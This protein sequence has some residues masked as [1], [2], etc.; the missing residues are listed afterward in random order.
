MISQGG[1]T[2]AAITLLGV[3]TFWLTPEEKWLSRQRIQQMYEGADSV[4]TD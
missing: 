3:V 4:P 2:F 1:I